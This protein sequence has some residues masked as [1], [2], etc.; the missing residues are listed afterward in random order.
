MLLFTNN[1]DD[2]E[3]ENEVETTYSSH[4]SIKKNSNLISLLGG[5]IAILLLIAAIVVACVSFDELW[6]VSLILLVIGVINYVL[7]SILSNIVYGFGDLIQ[8]TK[9]IAESVSGDSKD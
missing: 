4:V 3:D 6:F 2:D 5:I 1:F 9:E 7:F 8:Y